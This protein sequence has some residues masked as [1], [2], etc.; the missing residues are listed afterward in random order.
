MQCHAL[1]TSF[2]QHDGVSGAN[3]L[4]PGAASAVIPDQLKLEAP[5][6]NAGSIASRLPVTRSTS[7][8]D[9]PVILPITCAL[10]SVV[11]RLPARTG[12]KDSQV[13]S[14]MLDAFAAWI[15]ATGR[16]LTL[17]TH[18]TSCRKRWPLDRF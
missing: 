2:W 13:R 9:P 18:E 4:A 14:D 16:N 7:P 3:G 5:P 17:G 10:V 6:T 8:P 1:P 12:R 15:D 11:I